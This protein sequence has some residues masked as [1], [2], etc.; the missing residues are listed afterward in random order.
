MKNQS[1]QDRNKMLTSG[2]QIK[3]L[4]IAHYERIV[5]GQATVAAAVA[6]AVAAGLPDSRFSQL[7]NA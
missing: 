4:D 2:A 3:A 7:K 1:C 5:L 6:A